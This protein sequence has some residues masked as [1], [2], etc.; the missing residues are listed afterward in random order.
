MTPLGNILRARIA[1][2]GPMNV[3]DYMT[4]CLMHPKYGYYTTQ[5]VFGAAGDFI[6]APEI[7]QMFGEMI[8]LSL[9]TSWQ[10]Q[11]SPK[12]AI[13]VELGPGKGTLM[14]DLRRASSAIPGFDRLPIHFVEISSKMR[15]L[16]NNAIKSVTHHSDLLS[17]PNAPIYLIANE[18]F[19]ALPIRQFHRVA[20]AW[21]ERL[22]GEG[23]DKLTF[24]RAAP[25][26]F[27]FLN[28]RL[29]DTKVDDIVEYCP[30]LPSII[31]Q[32]S[33]RTSTNG[34]AAL[35]F[36]YGDWR[37]SGDTFQAITNHKMVNPLTYPGTSDITAH[38]DFESIFEAAKPASPSRLTPQGVFLE[39][40]GIT[41]RAKSL[42]EKLTGGNLESHIT[43][44]RRLTHP[45]EMGNLFKVMGI[46]PT[47]NLLPPGVDH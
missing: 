19:D 38:V 41:Q 12:D 35:I 39:R 10:A 7:S 14:K 42:A 6:T 25:Q 21:E 23:P 18:F 8:A 29:K 17:L 46:A 28:Q 22:I 1:T 9:G 47:P 34:G 11:G 26:L 32:I 24:G 44:H 20:T 16:Q 40:L 45:D 36:D 30:A 15:K 2:N 31:E 3:A 5:N 43:A 13:L 4:E 33:I 27:D 37:S